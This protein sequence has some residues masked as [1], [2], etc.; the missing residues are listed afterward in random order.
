MKR[1]VTLMGIA[2]CVATL[3]QAAPGGPHTQ[4]AATVGQFIATLASAVTGEPQTIRAAQDTLRR[5]GSTGE[6]DPS[7]ALTEGFVTRMAA[8]LGVSL[9]PGSNA[10]T[11][12]SAV[13][14]TAIVGRL[15]AALEAKPVFSTDGLPTACLSSSNRGECVNCC[16]ETGAAANECAHFCHSN[17][18]PPPSDNEPEP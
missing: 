13:R 4:Q 17:V 18:P 6:F 8:E 2:L 7:A 11:P 3:A 1:T 12:V 5:L 10:S 16:K 9:T 15:A 14:S